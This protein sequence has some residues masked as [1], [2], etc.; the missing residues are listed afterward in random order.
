[1]P[2]DMEASMQHAD[3]MA[4][5]PGQLAIWHDTRMNPEGAVAYNIGAYLEFV[6]TVDWSHF[7]RVVDHIVDTTPALR[8]HLQELADEAPPI[9]RIRSS[10][11]DDYVSLLDFTD[12]D[13]PPRAA[14]EWMKRDVR[15]AF[16]L[17]SF[18]LFRIAVLKLAEDW[19]FAYMVF[20]H[21]IV[22]GVGFAILVRRLAQAL[23]SAPAQ[24]L[25]AP[26][27]GSA[28][29]HHAYEAAMESYA[30]S[31]ECSAARRFWRTIHETPAPRVSLSMH[32]PHPVT[33]EEPVR[34]G[35]ELSREDIRAL[36][37]LASDLEISLT[38]VLLASVVLFVHKMTGAN[39]IPIGLPVHGRPAG[40]RHRF[41]WMCM[42]VLPLRF[43]LSEDLDLRSFFRSVTAR[44]REALGHQD[45]RYEAIKR[46]LGRLDEL[47]LFGVSVNVIRGGNAASD[48]RAPVHVNY[49][50]LS[51]GPIEDL[52][53]LIIDGVDGARNRRQGGTLALDFRGNPALYTESEL[54]A[55]A[56]N[57]LELLRALQQEVVA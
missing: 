36:G 21:I 17:T 13:E 16:D 54:R 10:V 50:S 7:R 39:D 14:R 45:Y 3:E 42:N 47:G 5:F 43:S 19:H 25:P 41:I 32:P 11:A 46:D 30:G 2:A 40:L 23:F 44:F 34:A 4:L 1:M 29:D 22:D 56:D 52:S 48:E 35:F 24:P 53:V 31:A 33:A 12:D 9:Q 18:P 37:A 55:L 57:F 6:G 49:Y 15:T 8:L 51:T 38:E 27:E 26:E 20:H 28:D